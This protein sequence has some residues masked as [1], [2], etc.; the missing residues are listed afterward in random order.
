MKTTL[1]ASGKIVSLP[2][3]ADDFDLYAS[4]P[5]SEDAA[6]ALETAVT[7]IVVDIGAKA[8]E[9]YMPTSKKLNEMLRTLDPIFN[10]YSDF[11]ATDSECYFACQDAI[12]KAVKELNGVSVTQ[13]GRF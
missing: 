11:G 1:L 9:G 2:C 8:A 12:H 4:M 5:G 7:D 10:K 3:S 6:R 13:L